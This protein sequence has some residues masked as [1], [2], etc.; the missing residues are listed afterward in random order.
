MNNA[1]LTIFALSSGQGRAGVAVVR[2]SGPGTAAAVTAIAGGL[3]APRRASLRRLRAPETGETLDRALVL[4]LPGPTS[5]TGD[6]MAEFHV[7]GG[8]AVLAGLLEA[9]GRLPG[10][11]PATPGE[12]TRRAFEAGKLDLTEAEGLADLIDAETEAQRRQALRQASGA[13]RLLYDGWRSDIIRAMAAIETALDFSDEADVPEAAHAAALPVAEALETAISRH[14]ADGRRGEILRDGLHVVIAGP[15]NAGKSS[16][17]NA[18]AGRDAAIVSHEPGTT[19]DVIDV[20]L[21]LGGYPL[22][23]SDTAGIREAPGA[24]SGK[25]CAAPWQRRSRG[26]SHPLADRTRRRSAPAAGPRQPPGNAPPG[27]E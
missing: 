26:R 21:D 9:L 27:A 24:W 14:L 15:P 16:L 10:F 18:L 5:F 13:A 11:R 12:F 25:A 4:W 8:R 2:V 19:R 23:L 6:D 1:N 3:P 17:L 7:H 22:I 20:R